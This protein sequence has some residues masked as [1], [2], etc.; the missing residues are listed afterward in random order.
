MWIEEIFINTFGPVSNGRVKDLAPG[1]NVLIG[2]NEAGKTTLLEFVRSIFFGFRK[3][4]PRANIYESPSGHARSGWVTV[5]MPIQ[6]RLRI[7]RTEK[8]GLREGLLQIIDEQGNGIESS[9]LAILRDG[10]ERRLF[11]SFFA[12]D[13]ESMRHLDQEALRG[14]I[15]ATALGSFQTNPLEV[16]K[17][18]DERIKALGRR[19]SRNN[20]TLEGIQIRIREI[21]KRLKILSEKPKKYEALKF[22]LDSV[23][24]RL[25]ECETEI[26][27]KESMLEGLADGLRFEEEW[28]KL[29]AM[30]REVMR[31]EDARRFPVDGTLRLEQALERLREAREGVQEEQKML[32]NIRN[33]HESQSPDT[34]LIENGN[35]IRSLG[36]EAMR[37]AGLPGEIEKA[38]S[39]LRRSN[40]LIDQQILELGPGWNREKV[41][42]SDTSMVVEQGIRSFLK[43]IRDCSER[44]LDLRS[45][46]AEAEERCARQAE[47]LQS[48]Q[49][50]LQ[51]L[52]PT[53][54]GHLSQE[55]LRGLQEWKEISTRVVDLRGRLGE[56]SQLVKKAMENSREL[57]QRLEE[58]HSAPSSIVP[59]APF[60][61]LVLLLSCSG[62]GLLVSLG[63]AVNHV[64]SALLPIGLLLVSAALVLVL[65]KVRG[66]RRKLDALNGEKDS[67]E[68]KLAQTASEI[69][70]IEMQRRSVIQRIEDMRRQAADIA[71]EI[72]G[73]PAAEPEE[74]LKAEQRSAVAEEPFRRYQMLEDSIRVSLA[75]A[76]VEENRRKE[77]EKSL[78]AAEQAMKNASAQWAKYFNEIGFEPGLEPEA[79]LELLRRL[80]E[81]KNAFQRKGQEEAD[82]AEMNDN[83]NKFAAQ[84]EAFASRMGC[85]VPADVSP[86]NQADAWVAA[87][88]A[89][90]EILAEKKI[91]L[92]KEQEREVRMGALKSKVEEIQDQI[93]VLLE[94]A[95]VADEER[96]RER[97]V[98]HDQYKAVERQRRVL[99]EN[100]V[101]GLRRP[102]EAAMRSSM[103]AQDWSRNRKLLVE[104]QVELNEARREAQELAGRR[105]RLEK[106]IETLEAEDEFEPL[107]AS[108]EEWVARLNTTAQEWIELKIASTLLS[109]TLRIYESERQ[110]RVLE[111]ASELLR[112]ITG[113]RIK[114]IFLPL[115]EDRVRVELPDGSRIDEHLLSRGT[116]EQVYLSLRL[117]HL[118]S[119][120]QGGFVVPILMDD[121]LVNFDPE[122]AGR[123]ADAL[124]RFSAETGV[125]VLFF[126]CHPHVA[127]LF[128]AET[129]IRELGLVRSHE[130]A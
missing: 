106:E 50:E 51:E 3:K 21:D 31:L 30:D 83:W 23:N 103:E 75:D 8:P 104:M 117:A 68:S 49:R 61:A 35:T 65:W 19:S 10:A 82:L 76:E 101:L 57:K 98:L 14:K 5:R 126:T 56:R 33:R 38:D 15:V 78:V 105:G 54:R 92:E 39:A 69:A 123:T 52:E 44:A 60:W 114:R 102:D 90:R 29:V 124:A 22:E 84:V 46:M 40:A 127:R 28:Q 72:L 43:T 130:S 17:R 63:Y 77:I 53:C 16:M 74:I 80:R 2:P 89:A 36:R 6:G 111:R 27:S 64:S 96:F 93:A 71:A 120:S 128:P 45:R 13:V 81:I 109:D 94:A 26:V 85:T 118:E 97:G 11:Q 9:S 66:D 55:S 95:G 4:I 122:R 7:E 59:L 113:D 108:R 20:G 99:I 70:E 129:P 86:V 34:I 62:M 18:V 32:D 73:D 112:S 25:R 100:L 121:V 48:M 37:L 12:F 42:S 110:P 88:Q 1:L 107:L 91:L 125:Q 87:E 24:N 115:D 67:L 119:H 47:K 58:L 79:A 41:A 116:L